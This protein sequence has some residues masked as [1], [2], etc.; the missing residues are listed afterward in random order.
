MLKI[1]LVTE[2]T[3]PRECDAFPR[4]P[5]LVALAGALADAGHEVT[6]YARRP[7]GRA[8]EEEAAPG[9]FRVVRL[10]RRGLADALRAAAPDVVHAHSRPVWRPAAA[11]ARALDVPFVHSLHAPG[12][13]LSA[14][15]HDSSVDL[16]AAQAA[17]RVIVGFSAQVRRLV[18]GGLLRD[19]IAV[20]P[21][22]VDVDHFTPDGV[23][24]QRRLPNRIVALGDLVPNSGFGTQVAALR[25][26][27]DTELV[28]VGGLHRGTHA[29]EIRD[30]ARSLGVADR[31]RL[32]GPVSRADLP[33]LLR[34]ADLLV[35]SPWESVFGVPALEAMACGVAVVANRLGGLTDTVVDNVTGTHVTPRKPRELAAAVLR[36]LTHKALCEQQG[37]AGRDRACARYSWARVAADTVHAYQRAGATEA[38]PAVT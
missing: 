21:Y 28:L 23:P 33:A 15:E 11:A 9:G 10:R 7:D 19:K 37:A 17:D 26:L 12:D 25:A 4:T 20:V 18:G 24:A 35:C 32:A 2:Q 31:V 22:G 30:Y 6:V 27:P 3:L 16:A 38:V 14:R 29:R 8:P 1:A 36:M 13:D 34:S 5:H